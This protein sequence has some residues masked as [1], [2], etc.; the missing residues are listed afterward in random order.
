M[1]QPLI[2][3]S[4]SGLSFEATTVPPSTET[5]KIVELFSQNIRFLPIC[6]ETI[7]GVGRKMR[8][9][10]VPGTDFFC[11]TILHPNGQITLI[12]AHKIIN[13]LQGPSSI[14]TI[15]KIKQLENR[16]W[17]LAYLD[18]HDQLSIWPHIAA[19]AQGD[20]SEK[21]IFFP[22]N[23]GQVKHMFRN[24]EGHFPDTSANRN[25]ILH[26][27]RPENKIGNLFANPSIEVYYKK[28]SDNQFVWVYV[29]A[30]GEITN[31]GCNKK[32]W[33]WNTK[34]FPRGQGRLENPDGKYPSSNPPRGGGGG[35]GRR[36]PNQ[37]H[38]ANQPHP[39]IGVTP[40]NKNFQEVLQQTKLTDS[41]NTTH[42]GNPVPA[43]GGTGGTIGGVACGVDYIQGL[44]DKA[45]SVFEKDH[46]F[47]VP[48]IDGQIPFSQEQLRQ[49]LRELAIGI[50]MHGAV[51][52]F[53]LHFNQN[54][55]L[56]SVMD[57]AYQNTM[58]G[59]VIGMLDYFMK[60]Y[61]N[62]GVFQEEFIDKQKPEPKKQKPL[63]MI[64]RLYNWWWPPASS[65]Q[66]VVAGQQPMSVLDW[67]YSWWWPSS[68]AQKAL[69]LDKLIDFEEYCQLYLKGEDKNYAS[70]RSMQQKVKISGLLERLTITLNEEPE[71][72]TN[73]D[74]F[75][76]SFRIIAKQNSFQKEDNLF[77]IDADFDVLY[78][79]EPSPMYQEKLEEYFRKHGEMPASYQELVLIYE[80]MS[81][82]IHDHMVKMPMCREYFAMLGVINF[83][84]SYFSTLK[85]HHKL[86]EL[87][88]FEKIDARGCPPVFPHLPLRASATEFI[89]MNLKEVISNCLK[90]NEQLMNLGFSRLFDHLMSNR[91]L[92]SFD[93][94]ETQILYNI[95]RKE[96]ESN[97]L[98]LCNPPF[99]R[100]LLKNQQ[101]LSP[102]FEQLTQ[103]L[104]EGLFKS[105]EKTMDFHK[106]LYYTQRLVKIELVK[107]FL[108]ET[109]HKMPNQ[110]KNISR[111][112]P[113]NGLFNANVVS[114]EELEKNKRIVGGCGMQLKEQRVQSSSKASFIL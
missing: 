91:S 5:K 33:S 25:L 15:R 77:V 63:S 8:L 112:I 6:R 41:Y 74:G 92:E 75:K 3:T 73:F 21:S 35:G 106:N 82:Q 18:T 100:Y 16:H 28:I 60:G 56:F 72:L 49:I 50:Y 94:D 37:A 51:P 19:A 38:T 36:A 39:K 113:Y 87:A 54:A 90:N 93:R 44:F 64:E 30:N 62:G 32:H 107:R 23:D 61:L 22:P 27:V 58:V 13:P 17:K 111:E 99:R 78:T 11:G 71:E 89:R 103:S 110:I 96:L 52:F 14:Q 20:G 86:P 57:P 46:Y 68:S 83:F 76:N 88:A 53:S 47:C 102:L 84:S 79:I 2:T 108:S 31:A 69:P 101:S 12:P 26:A 70:V 81:K 40:A 98:G 95:L 97:V 43:K 105:F 24:D 80:L 65:N 34:G 9:W 45:E 66:L 85:K 59:R 114:T 104:L 10:E 42:R 29:K 48:L 7:D 67:L 1:V 55:E 109:C 4:T